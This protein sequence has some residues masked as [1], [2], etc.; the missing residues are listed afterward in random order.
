MNTILI[1]SAILG[2]IL[3]FKVWRMCDDI[4]DIKETLQKNDNGRT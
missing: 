2:V 3:F 4:H 1:V